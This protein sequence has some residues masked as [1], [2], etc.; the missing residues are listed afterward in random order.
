MNE[1]ITKTK[2]L[3]ISNKLQ[4]QHFIFN[5]ALDIKL[6][7]EF[8]GKNIDEAYLI[9]NMFL[10]T[11]AKEF[12][13]TVDQ[14]SKADFTVV[15][16]KLHKMKPNF[17]MVGLTLFYEKFSLIASQLNIPSLRLTSLEAIDELKALF[18]SH[19]LPI[20]KFE[21]VRIEYYLNSIT[22]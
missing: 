22:K 21:I 13:D 5:E 10:N 11:T 12:I 18:Q 3:P 4:K 2:L 16:R 17:K 20:I 7:Q 8:Y 9:F 19:H 14:I 6:L 15:K 1:P